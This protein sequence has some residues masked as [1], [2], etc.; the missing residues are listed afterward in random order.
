M[1]I[2]YKYFSCECLKPVLLEVVIM[3]PSNF[4]L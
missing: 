3:M 4:L 1:C 2:S